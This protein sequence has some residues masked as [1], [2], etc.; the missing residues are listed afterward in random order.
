MSDDPCAGC[1]T[2]SIKACEACEEGNRRIKKCLLC[3]LPVES[4]NVYHPECQR[5]LKTLKQR[6]RRR[7]GGIKRTEI[8]YRWME[9]T[10][11]VEWLLDV[12]PN[13]KLE[14]VVG[15]TGLNAL[16]SF[17]IHSRGEI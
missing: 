11:G 1:E 17:R 8:G 10:E 3:G 9:V 13:A 2:A 4:R 7:R 15:E 5:A 12:K 16:L 6:M 14:K